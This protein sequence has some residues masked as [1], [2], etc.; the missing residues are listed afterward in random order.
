V[1]KSQEENL[2][3]DV[4]DPSDSDLD[5]DLG[6]GSG[7]EYRN[8]SPS[9]DDDFSGS[10]IMD[11]DD[12]SGS[13]KMDASGSEE[14]MED[15]FVKN[16]TVLQDDSDEESRR[17][18][19]DE[20]LQATGYTPLGKLTNG[21]RTLRDSVKLAKRRG[22]DPY[23]TLKEVEDSCAWSTLDVRGIEGETV[24]VSPSSTENYVNGVAVLDYLK[25][26]KTLFKDE[27]QN[28]ACSSAST[29]T[30]RR[31]CFEHVSPKNY[32]VFERT[33]GE[34]MSEM[35]GITGAGARPLFDAEEH[36]RAGGSF[37]P[38]TIIEIFQTETL[39][40]MQRGDPL[41]ISAPL[42]SSRHKVFGIADFLI[43]SDQ[44]NL[45]SPGSLDE[46]EVLVPNSTTLLSQHF[47]Y[48]VIDAKYRRLELCADGRH[49]VNENCIAGY[50]S[51][52]F[53]YQ[54]CL[55][56]ISGNNT[57]R[58]AFLL[59]KGFSITQR[60]ALRRGD[61]PLERLGR[62][63]FD[64]Y[65][66]WIPSV[67]HDARLFLR[68][69]RK[70]K[71]LFDQ[72]FSDLHDR[73]VLGSHANVL[74]VN[75]KKLEYFYSYRMRAKDY[76]GANVTSFM[77]CGKKELTAA[78]KEGFHK[79]TDPQF[80]KAWLQR[81]LNPFKFREVGSVFDAM[82]LPIGTTLPS[83]LTP[84]IMESSSILVGTDWTDGVFY[85]DIFVDM[86]PFPDD[87]RGFATC[88]MVITVLDP[89][90]SLQPLVLLAKDKDDD[91]LSRF[92]E[93]I[94]S[95][96]KQEEVSVPPRRVRLWHYGNHWTSGSRFSEDAIASLLYDM[97]KITR[98]ISF[99]V[100]GAL[101]RKLDDMGKFLPC[102]HDEV[103]S[104][105]D[106][107]VHNVLFLRRILT[108]MRLIPR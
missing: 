13:D 70:N 9:S 50:K 91:I 55:R 25:A 67:A 82:S 71:H 95:I 96:V 18:E 53:W 66:T 56:D 58:V 69:L 97:Y 105:C 62:V 15:C 31:K 45:I 24:W 54:E 3:L 98:S 107:L 106:V 6:L 65:D 102:C 88:F 28:T 26:T 16:M 33:M 52:V 36:R 32:D 89:A 43:R 20:S 99:S 41:I 7:S 68:D 51:Q 12:F 74:L 92:S 104:D 77:N 83:F 39:P 44:I 5:S 78:L 46:D 101:N 93:T 75:A 85:R 61:H 37:D 2:E 38:K 79:V 47:W 10:D 30:L 35:L 108:H 100:S 34:K 60:G 81:N 22:Y 72:Q 90:L 94:Q 86:K 76:V 27:N 19:P 40:R 59:G 87:V 11:D 4:S 84:D 103:Q 64:G 73:G 48:V 57:P 80:T 21:I 23:R 29:S 63:S 8:E 14:V 1:S 17:G 49:L 42:A